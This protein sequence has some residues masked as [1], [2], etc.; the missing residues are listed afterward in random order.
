MVSGGG[1]MRWTE[2]LRDNSTCAFFECESARV[3]TAGVSKPGISTDVRG[4]PLE[5]GCLGALSK[6][7]FSSS[8]LGVM[9]DDS[10]DE[11]S[12]DVPGVLRNVRS[13]AKSESPA[14]LMDEPEEA[15]E[16]PETFRAMSGYVCACTLVVEISSVGSEI[17]LRSMRPWSLTLPPGGPSLPRF[18]RAVSARASAMVDDILTGSKDVSVEEKV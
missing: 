18:A 2:R 14:E 6:N 17:W 4:P 15:D 1:D 12:A 11:L 9:G 16:V 8:V 5:A 3:G 10:T 7:G 13:P